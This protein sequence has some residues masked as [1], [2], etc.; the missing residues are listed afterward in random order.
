MNHFAPS[1]GGNVSGEARRLGV[2]EDQL[3]DASASLIPFSLPQSLNRQFIK[4]LSSNSIHRYPDPNHYELKK[5]IGNSHGIDPSMII[6]G[7]GAAE[8][9]TWA[10]KDASKTGLN[11]LLSPCFADYERALKCWNGTYTHLPIPLSWHSRYPQPFPLKP[12]TDVIWINNPHNP[13]GQLWSHESLAKLLNNH[14][15]VICD[16]AFLPLV[17]NGED[18]SL[19]PL[20]VKH[21]NLIVIRSLTKLFGIPGLR[22]GYA[23]SNAHRLTNWSQ[24]RDPWPMN[25]IAIAA[26]TMLMS[27]S[28]L[29]SNWIHKIQHWVK[30][31]GEWLY[32]E[33][34]NIPGITPH[35]SSTNFLLISAKFS[36]IPIK[37]LL[38]KERI[39]LRDCRSF[40]GLGENWLRIGLQKRKENRK[41]IA[42]L[43]RLLN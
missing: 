29:L 32:K 15:L 27:D 2:K 24:W 8:L 6:P 18:Q 20:T 1:H 37:E 35:L 12:Q 36:L 22:L 28:S 38:A 23:V 4:I 11:G 26:G 31:E 41:I 5:A 25:A 7:N 10:A 40:K 14:S 34:N 21:S 17:P 9:F 3:L 16:E 42:A 19:L 13:T 33:L 30:E 39:L 43:T